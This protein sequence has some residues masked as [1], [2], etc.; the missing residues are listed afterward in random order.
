M[1]RLHDQIT[2]KNE[3][4]TKKP[5]NSKRIRLTRNIREQLLKD[6]YHGSV[7]ELA[8]R[9]R[10]PYG[11]IYNVIH[12]RVQSISAR[13]YRRIF[14]AEPP[15]QTQQRTDGAYFRAMVDLW[16]Y[17]QDDVTKV[18]LYWE[19]YPQKKSPKP[20]YRIFT[21]HVTSV[22]TRLVE[23]MENKFAQCGV[24]PPTLQE[25]IAELQDMPSEDRIS[26]NRIRPVLHYL[27]TVLGTHPTF[28]LKQFVKRYETGELK[29]ISRKRYDQIINL[30]QRVEHLL[31]TDARDALNRL[32]EDIYGGKSGYTLFALIADEL[33]FL[34][35]H[36]GISPK[37]FLGRGRRPYDTGRVK[38]I[39]TW[40]A[41]NIR[42]ACREF[43]R[44]HP[45]LPLKELPAAHASRIITALHSLLVMRAADL[46][47]KDEGGII[48]KQVLT[49]IYPKQEYKNEANGFTQFDRASSAL[50]MKR[51]AFD[52]MVARN[53][54]IFR[55]V[56]R[57]QRRWYISDLYLNELRRKGSFELITAKY[58]LM[59]N[60]SKTSKQTNTCMV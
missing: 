42:R 59:A 57:Y 31:A 49:P 50:G 45:E 13:H 25:W 32:K 6:V 35:K 58:E 22:E 15:H 11:L 20:D 19:F 39:A 55:E 43:I 18:D 21:G 44:L 12:G 30:Q 41:E 10:L 48:E 52:L 29:S 37:R 24:N 8:Q 60:A 46:L 17:L 38:R 3:H 27:S 9:T 40:R 36:A 16:L 5:V 4:R 56:G 23:A 51:K 2:R 26:Y 53:C 34:K 47:E 14:N 33:T 1:V 7:S 28:L 54:N